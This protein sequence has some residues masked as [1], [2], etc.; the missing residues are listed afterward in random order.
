MDNHNLEVLLRKQNRLTTLLCIF[1][2]LSLAITLVLLVVVL[3]LLPKLS[4]LLDQADAALAELTALSQQLRSMDMEG[5]LA[6]LDALLRNVDG[7]VGNV[8]S[9]VENADALVAGIQQDM[10]QT[11]EKINAIDFEKL[12]QAIEDLAAVIQPIAK[13]F[14]RS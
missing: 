6:D 12:N 3:G 10:G 1:S 7:L 5:L 9:L 14:G 11:L 2:G 13:L 8:D 4:G